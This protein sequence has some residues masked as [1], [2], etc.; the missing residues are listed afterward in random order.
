MRLVQQDWTAGQIG[1]LRGMLDT[2][3][4]EP[5]QR[6]CRGWEW[7]YFLSQCDGDLLTLYGHTDRVQSVAWSPDGKRLASASWDRVFKVWDVAG[8]HELSPA[9]F[10]GT[11]TDK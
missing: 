1:R 10:P 6:D 2:H 3:I 5:E 8:R 11:S 9:C 7:Y 4:P